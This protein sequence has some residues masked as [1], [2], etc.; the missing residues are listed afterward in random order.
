MEVHC[1][2]VFIKISRE[3]QLSSYEVHNYSNYSSV[4]SSS[5]FKY[6]ST[7]PFH[8]SCALLILLIHH[9][10]GPAFTINITL[11]YLHGTFDLDVMTGFINHLFKTLTSGRMRDIG[12]AKLMLTR[13]RIGEREMT[14][15]T[16][17]SLGIC[18][19]GAYTR[20]R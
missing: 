1:R 11:N 12:F 19:C 13:T 16:I 20:R 3:V 5:N 17:R 18:T 6:C 2:R 14:I 7:A 10:R 9:L 4:K 8:D 15:R